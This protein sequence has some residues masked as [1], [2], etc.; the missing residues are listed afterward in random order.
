[1]KFKAIFVMVAVLAVFLAG[2]TANPAATTLLEYQRTGGI[3]GLDDRLVIDSAG[4][5]ALTRKDQEF[6][7]TLS[8]DELKAIEDGL[9]AVKF[10]QLEEEY[11]PANQG[12]DLFDYQLTYGGYT[13]HLVDTAVPEGMLPV[14]ELLNQLMEANS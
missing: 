6:S 14:L 4:K 13:V 12:A 9:A 8:A 5:A 7:F 3:A 10:S 11:L 1:M 2:C